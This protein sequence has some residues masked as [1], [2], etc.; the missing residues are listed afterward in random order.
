MGPH[1][2]NNL[3]MVISCRPLLPE[4]KRAHLLIGQV[5]V[6][7]KVG[8][9]VTNISA[10][11]ELSCPRGVFTEV[12]K[13]GGSGWVESHCERIVGYGWS[14]AIVGMRSLVLRTLFPFMSQ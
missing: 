14:K 2:I 7:L 9:V 8:Q 10:S 12:D 11:D 6:V 1:T 5:R 13:S 3:G 4:A